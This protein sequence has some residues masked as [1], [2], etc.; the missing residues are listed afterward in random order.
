MSGFAETRWVDRKG[1]NVVQL[2]VKLQIYWKNPFV[3]EY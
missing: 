3:A 1:S 2:A